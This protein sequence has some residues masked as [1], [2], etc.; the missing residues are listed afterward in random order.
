[1][2]E[3][4]KTIIINEWIDEIYPSKDLFDNLFM[5]YEWEYK[6]NKIKLSKQFPPRIENIKRQIKEKMIPVIKNIKLQLSVIFKE[7]LDEHNVNSPEDWAKNRYKYKGDIIDLLENIYNDQNDYGNTKKFT[8][9]IFFKLYDDIFYDEILDLIEGRKEHISKIKFIESIPRN[10]RYMV[11]KLDFKKPENGLEILRLS[12]RNLESFISD[13]LYKIERI[14]GA[15]ISYIVDVLIN[16]SKDIYK[17]WYKE[18]NKNNLL[19]NTIKK[20]QEIYNML[21]NLDLN[22]FSKT[23]ADLNIILHVSHAS[24]H[25]LEYINQVYPN[26]NHR[27]LEYLSNLPETLLEKWDN[28]LKK[29]VAY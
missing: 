6:Y 27:S 18:W 15:E 8:K 29:M 2:K 19:E 25:F 3:Y 20:I 28:E 9:Q 24:G 26:V 23:M 12:K 17:E 13:A 11:D 10:K 5:L 1:M 22:D 7:W 16:N 14:G 4:L 21:L